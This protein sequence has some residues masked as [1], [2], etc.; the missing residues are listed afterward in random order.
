MFAAIF[1]VRPGNGQFQKY[2]EL[3]KSLRSELEK[4]DGFIENERFGSKRDAGRVLSLSVWRDEKA[5]IRWRT[6]GMH[7][8]V[9]KIGHYEVFD[10]Y[11]LRVGEITSDTALP[12]GQALPQRRFDETVTGRAKAVTICEFLPDGGAAPAEHELVDA[13]CLPAAGTQGAVDREMFESIYRPGKLLLLSAWQ[14]AASA[15]RWTSVCPAQ[16]QLRLRQVRVIRDYGKFDRAEA[17][18]FFPTADSGGE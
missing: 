9:Q 6:L 17:P 7:H 14:D 3:A 11:H 10:D 18:Q 5:L 16:G 2:L 12:R 15:T 13:L 8:E 4:I 1:V